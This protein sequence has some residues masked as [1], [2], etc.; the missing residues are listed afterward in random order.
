MSEQKLTDWFPPQQAPWEPGVYERDYE[1]E[2]PQY[3]YWD[4]KNWYY[5]CSDVNQTLLK[6]QSRTDFCVCTVAHS[7]RGLAEDPRGGA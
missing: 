6:Y 5:G 3:Q 1:M 7:W 2:R 4:G